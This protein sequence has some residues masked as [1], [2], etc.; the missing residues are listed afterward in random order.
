[1]SRIFSDRLWYQEIDLG[2]KSE[3]ELSNIFKSHVTDLF[4][5]LEAFEFEHVLRT[6]GRTTRADLCLISQRNNRWY[7]V[8]VE[9]SSH[10]YHDHILPQLRR[11]KT[12]LYDDELIKRFI[13]NNAARVTPTMEKLMLEKPPGFMVVVDSNK[14]IEW[15]KPL[16]CEGVSLL[17][18]RLFRNDEFNRYMIHLEGE[19]P[20]QPTSLLTVCRIK[21][22]GNNFSQL[23]I[24]SPSAIRPD[25][26]KISIVYNGM[27]GEW[28]IFRKPGETIIFIHRKT[29][30]GHKFELHLENGR[31][32]LKDS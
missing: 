19:L 27:E 5:D 20:N 11:F 4:P 26:S 6:G 28:T 22:G 23:I 31:Y 21:E 1:M 16:K 17:E 29:V 3:K 32:V 7:I 12:A 18:L 9:K 15:R 14:K 10:D 8:E 30:L 2:A 25:L 24:S 13:A